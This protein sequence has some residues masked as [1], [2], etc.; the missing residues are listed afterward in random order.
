MISAPD[1][2]IIPIPG[3]KISIEYKKIENQE[4]F[5]GYLNQVWAQRME[6]EKPLTALGKG[7][8]QWGHPGFCEVCEKPAQFYMDWN[9]SD[10][11]T[12]NYRERLVCTNCFLNNRQRFTM[13][14][15]KRELEAP[16]SRGDIYLF[17]QTTPFYKCALKQLRPATVIG[18]E[19]LGFQ[20]APG[21]LVNGLRHED[22]MNLSFADAS[23]D[24]I[25]A[26]DVFEHVPVYPRAFAESA[27]VLRENG[28]LIFSIPFYSNQTAT[29][30]RAWLENGAVKFFL[31]GQYHGPCLVFHD[32]GWDMLPACQRAGFSQV[33]MLIYYSLNFGYWGNGCQFIFIAEK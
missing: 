2:Q 26:N 30:A 9:F 15:L 7:K 24:L 33:Y 11:Q 27:R 5:M 8:T 23:L 1:F 16:G 21:A 25:V 10:Q 28:K 13:N 29:V 18:S 31:P 4:Q 3:N 32:Y 12:P 20:H 22:A 6:I 14:Y 19:Y 17:E